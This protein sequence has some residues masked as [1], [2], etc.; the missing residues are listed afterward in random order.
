MTENI[1]KIQEIIIQPHFFSFSLDWIEIVISNKLNKIIIF[2]RNVQVRDGLE[3]KYYLKNR[4]FF[5]QAVADN[6]ILKR[7]LKMTKK[8]IALC[9]VIIVLNNSNDIFFFK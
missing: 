1:I 4:F 5:N 2:V 3:Y 8:Y 9:Y 6:L 7:R